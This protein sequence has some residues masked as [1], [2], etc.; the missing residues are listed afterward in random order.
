MVSFL[1]LMIDKALFYQIFRKGQVLIICILVWLLYFYEVY[2]HLVWAL[3]VQRLKEDVSVL[4]Q[5]ERVLRLQL[6]LEVPNT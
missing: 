1:P 3:M 5:V 6:L 2:R 4:S